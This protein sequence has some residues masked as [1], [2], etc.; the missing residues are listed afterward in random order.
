[1]WTPRWPA[2]YGE[3]DRDCHL[4]STQK[5]R[6]LAPLPLLLLPLLPLL[7]V[8]PGCSGGASAP[9]GCWRPASAEAPAAGALRR[10]QKAAAAPA[11][12]SAAG[13][14]DIEPEAAP[15]APPLWVAAKLSPGRMPFLGGPRSPTPTTWRDVTMRN[16]RG[17]TLPFFPFETFLLIWK[18]NCLGPSACLRSYS[19]CYFY[20]RWRSHT[21]AGFLTPK[22]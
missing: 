7:K 5:L 21:A 6:P 3:W 9:G 15:T 20:R 11:L 19:P 8:L 14:P 1:M 4:S 13:M 16:L 18:W 2:G 17:R 10:P 22:S 12:P